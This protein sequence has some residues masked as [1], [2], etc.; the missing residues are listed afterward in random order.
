MSVQWWAHWLPALGF[1]MLRPL[2]AVLIVPVFNQS[3]LGGT[4]I[5]NAMVLLIALPLAPLAASWPV[6]GAALASWPSLLWMLCSELAIGVVIGFTAAVPFW[7]LDMAGSLIDTMRG[8][9]MANVLNPM[10]G[11]QSSLLGALFSQIFGLLFV[12]NGGL[13]ELFVAL[14]D[15]YRTLPPA[16]APA[17]DV[18][19]LAFVLADWQLMYELCLRFSMPALIGILLVDMA[20]GLVN[21]SAQQLN[22][23]FLSMPVKSAFAV[24]LIIV[25]M[26]FAFHPMIEYSV[27]LSHHVR[28]LLSPVR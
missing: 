12:A 26:G 1:C 25:G 7:A 2:G 4:L 21:R 28:R 10:L 3:A 20:L 8:A 13:N 6:L 11:Q 23:F 24:L 17:R 27:T 18:H 14:Y 15:S 5:R 19:W 22:V 9:T 16:V